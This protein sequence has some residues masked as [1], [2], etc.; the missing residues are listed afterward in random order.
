MAATAG[1]KLRIKKAVE[2]D[3]L[4]KN[5]SAAD[6]FQLG[7]DVGFEEIECPTMPDERV[8]GRVAQVAGGAGRGGVEEGRGKERLADSLGDEPGALEVSALFGRSRSGG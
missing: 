8:A 6:R 1:T 7:R 4:P 2:L 5:M 3:M